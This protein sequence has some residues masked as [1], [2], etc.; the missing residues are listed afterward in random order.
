MGKESESVSTGL[1]CVPGCVGRVPTT[2]DLNT[3]AKV[4]RF[5]REPYRDTM[6]WCIYYF[7]PRGGILLQKYRDR[8]GRFM[9]ILFNSIRVRCQ[10]DS[11]GCGAGFILALNPG[12]QIGLVPGTDWA[13]IVQNKVTLLGLAR[14]SFSPSTQG[15]TGVVPGIDWASIVQNKEKTWVCA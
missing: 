13:S 14:V 15:Q 9:A 5:K 2:P 12:G 6:W 11:P 3:S 10:F 8:D 4:S 7:L 1:W